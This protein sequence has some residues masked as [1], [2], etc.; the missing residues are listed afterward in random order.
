M[1]IHYKGGEMDI[2]KKWGYR[3]IN[4]LER[5]AYM[6]MLGQEL[7]INNLE[8][9]VEVLRQFGNKDCTAMADEELDK[10]HHINH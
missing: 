10:I 7:K 8:R 4:S 6:V 9:E 3:D 1:L 5:R 2:F